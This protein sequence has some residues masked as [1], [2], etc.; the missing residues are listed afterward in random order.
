MECGCLKLVCRNSVLLSMTV[1]QLKPRNTISL[2][3]YFSQLSASELKL[4]YHNGEI[5]AMAG[6]QPRHVEI[7][8]NIVGLFFACLKAKGCS[9]LVSDLLVKAGDCNNFYF[10]DLVIV[11]QERKYFKSPGG[12]DA[13]ENPE[14]IIEILSP[15]TELFD[16][17][18]K[19]DCYRT[20]PGFKEYILVSSTKKQIEVQTRLSDVEWLSHIYQEGD[21][22]LTINGCEILFEDVYDKV[23][24]DLGEEV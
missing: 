19:L 22:A 21:T 1:S 15:G 6:A 17:P 11:C 12:L 2:Q 4:E 18:Y 9:I 23:E 13:L 8:S 20:I 3:D 24:F 5:V 14:V 16:R 10:P 7:Q